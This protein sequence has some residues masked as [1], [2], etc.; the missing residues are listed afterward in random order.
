MKRLI[1]AILAILMIAVFFTGCKVNTTVDAKYVDEFVKDYATPQE[2][3]DGSVEYEFESNDKYEQF[4]TDYYEK[5]QEDSRLEIKSSG[6]YS[7]YN[8]D[9]T[10][11]IVGVTPESYEK[12]GEEKLKEEAQSVGEAALKYQMNTKDPKGE[13]EVTYRNANTSEEY[14]TITVKA[15]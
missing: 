9:I 7:Y 2:N 1:C 14:F 5:V 10:E 3:E 13:L 11:V 15:E 4:L 8:P 12:L 6:Q